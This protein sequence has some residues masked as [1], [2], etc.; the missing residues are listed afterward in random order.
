[1]TLRSV[2]P[3]GIEGCRVGGVEELA[4][5]GYVREF[6]SATSAGRGDEFGVAVVNEVGKWCRLAVLFA[7]EEQ[8]YIGRQHYGRGGESRLGGRHQSDE[9]VTLRSVANVIMVLGEHHEP[10]GRHPG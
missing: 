6:A 5:F 1:M 3:C 4:L 7:H 8:R 2:E 10:L 9:S